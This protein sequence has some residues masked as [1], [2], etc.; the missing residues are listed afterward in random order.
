M[1]KLC[2]L[3]GYPLEHSVSGVMHNAAFKELSLEYRFELLP[4]HPR[5][6]EGLLEK[7]LRHNWVRGASVTIPHKV[8]VLRYLDEVDHLAARIGAVNTIVNKRGK[9]KGFNTDGVGAMRSLEEAFGDLDGSRVVVLGA[10][11]ASRAI[12]YHLS[13]VAE[14]LVI[15]NRTYERALEL[16]EALREYPEC[17]ASLSASPLNRA[18]IMEALMDSELLVNTT[19]IGMWPMIGE[20]PV[21]VGLL[22]PDLM[23]FDVIYNPPKTKLLEEAEAIGART[24]N[25]LDML[26]YQGAEAFRLW[27]G[28]EAPIPVM[29]R[30]VEEALGIRA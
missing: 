7:G 8:R 14:R 12:S 10:G 17:R 27:T 9:L 20:S 13:T 29:R 21:D 23:V 22:R 3:L 25:G 4:A 24:L 18:S 2:Y 26:I 30:A 16:V 6:L 1:V 19:P 11:G 28:R 5:D 15:I